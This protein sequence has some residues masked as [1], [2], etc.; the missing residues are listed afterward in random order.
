[1]SVHIEHDGPVWT[2]VLDRPER[3]N[4]VD[5]P[6]ASALADAFRA[7]D[8]D[9]D[10]PPSPSCGERAGRSARAR[11]CTRCPTRWTPT[12]LPTARWGRPGCRWRTGDRRGERA[13]RR[14][15]N[16][17]RTVV[18][19]ARRRGR[20]GVRRLLPPVGRAAHRRWDGPADPRRRAGPRARP[21][22]HRPRRSTPTRRW[23]WGSRTGS[24]PPG[25]ARAAAQELAAQ[26]A[27]FPQSTVRS[28]RRS[29]YD[30]LGLT[31]RDALAQE[32]TL[33]L[34][35]LQADGVAGAAR[36]AS[37]EGREGTFD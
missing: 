19:P 20:C 8:A 31:E 36:F 16:G 21:D 4:A 6:T 34:A 7:F 28:D 13:R 35:S 22:P 5:G 30:A 18:R 2:V 17:T 26:I 27:A 37:G 1:M 32:F 11:I 33:G 14:R 10:A 3:R 29:A 12:C 9:D 15:R 25:T 23:P 24:S